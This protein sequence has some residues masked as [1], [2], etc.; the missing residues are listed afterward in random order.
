MVGTRALFASI[1][2]SVALVAAA[3][4]SLLAV[5][6][7]FAFGGWSDS[8]SESARQPA[9]VVEGSTLTRA[10]DGH[11]RTRAGA[12]PIVVAAR[13]RSQSASGSDARLTAPRRV[14]PAAN[15]IVTTRR[16]GAATPPPSLSA[17]VVRPVAPHPA[18]AKKQ[19]GDVVD[20]VGD[21]LSATVQGTGA[22]L[23]QA[24]EPLAPPVSSAVQK[25]L[26]VVATV[27]NRATDGL[28]GTLNTLLPQK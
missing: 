25:V 6:A 16:A 2:A 22:A 26:N 10:R 20:K 21:G 12:R 14:R 3:A 13:A 1:G 17:P 5:S 11:A 23:A 4:L 7:V 8:V 18:A 24:T 27:L 15:R 28:A 19:T 9:L